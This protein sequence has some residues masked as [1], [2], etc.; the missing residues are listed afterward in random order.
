MP[1]HEASDSIGSRLRVVANLGRDPNLR[2][3]G[4]SYIGFKLTELASWIVVLIFAFERGGVLESGIVAVAMFVPPSLI[5]PF[6]SSVGDRFPRIRVL[7]FAYALMTI[8]S[9]GCA[10]ALA[11]GWSDWIVYGWMMAL[12]ISISVSQPL[13]TS[14]LVSL[15]DTAEQ[16]AAANVV[17]GL[18]ES[19]SYFVGPLLAA[20][21]LPPGGPSAVFVALAMTMGTSTCL[22]LTMNPENRNL[23]P[24]TERDSRRFWRD[25]RDAMRWTTHEPGVPLIITVAAGQDI[26]IGSIDVLFVAIAFDLLSTGDS[27]AAL[28]NAAFGAG[29]IGGALLSV[30]LV[31]SRMIGAF[32]LVGGLVSGFSL[33]V[34]AGLAAPTAALILLGFAGVGALL[35][36]MS[37]RILVQRMIPAFRMNQALGIL[38][39]ISL[40]AFTLGTLGMAGLIDRVG[41]TKA[42]MSLG[43]ALSTIML[44]LY[45]PIRRLESRYGPPSREV[46][47]ALRALEIFRP[48]GVLAIEQLARS[49]SQIDAGPGDVLI[50][51]G[52]PGGS[53]F[54]LLEGRVEAQVDSVTV[55]SQG[56]G[57]YFGEISPLR[58][59]PRTA[60]VVATSP[61]RLI[62]ID[63]ERFV[64]AVSSH[65]RTLALARSVAH[66]RE[67]GS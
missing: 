49:A 13:Q 12:C 44:L 41:A 54:V 2:K 30:N 24:R 23:A 33:I 56:P 27:G 46:L 43:I 22:A 15:A 63:P 52:D 61:V 39:S 45:A 21:L 3:L 5:T 14:V 48:L 6:A 59:I 47:T 57:E 16:L 42:L 60:T 19:A 40:I 9:A 36:D 62:E 28:L 58:G 67:L 8:C 32:L 11:F 38:E 29:L 18:I 66:K 25:F 1:E 35:T 37:A 4:L 7:A 55:R 50:R 34:L 31:G 65:P 51:Q 53:F 64:Q 20:L 17:N 10:T 26:L